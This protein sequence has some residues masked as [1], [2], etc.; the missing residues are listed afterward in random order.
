M[1]ANGEVKPF[2]NDLYNHGADVILNGHAHMY[3][4]FALQDPA[5]V[6]VATGIRQFVVGTGGRGLYG[7]GAPAANS[8]VLNNKTLGVLELTLSAA[9]YGWKFATGRPF[10]RTSRT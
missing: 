10:P 9:S 7:I 1:G 6:A 4:R 8:E 3:E 5:G 2:W